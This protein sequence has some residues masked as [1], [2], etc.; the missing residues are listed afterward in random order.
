MRCLFHGF[1]KCENR[2]YYAHVKKLTI[3]PIFFSPT[4]TCA[5]QG[6]KKKPRIRIEFPCGAQISNSF[7][8]WDKS[9]KS[10]TISVMKDAL[11]SETFQE[12][13]E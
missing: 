5:R 3:N 11:F 7:F 6:R 4:S 8:V 2:D 13:S 1:L 9:L 12:R 10:T